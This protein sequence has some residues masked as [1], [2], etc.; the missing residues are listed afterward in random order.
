[1]AHGVPT[2]LAPRLDAIPSGTHVISDGDMSGWLMFEAPA[3]RP[4]FDIRVEAYSPEHIR[5]F[6]AALQA[7]PGWTAY[8]ER[9]QARAALL[10]SNAPLASALEDQWHWHVTG[11]DGRYVLLEA[12]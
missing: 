8:L 4:V 11:A 10:R 1:V 5:G 2:T 3:L 12:P 7:K 6:V 9:T